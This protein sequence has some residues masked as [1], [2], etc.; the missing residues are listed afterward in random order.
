[1]TDASIRPTARARATLAGCCIV[2][3]AAFATAS[4]ARAHHGWA[5]TLDEIMTLEGTIEDIYIGNPHVTL[6][7]RTA[8]GASWQVDLA[9][10]IR[11]VRAGFDEDAARV[12]DAVMLEGQRSRDPAELWMKAIRVHVNGRVY[13]VYADRVHR[14]PAP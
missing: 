7:V 2:L 11:T 1:M 5:W 3:A 13:D 8:D 12:G 14:L 10:L 9:P 6:K 4:P